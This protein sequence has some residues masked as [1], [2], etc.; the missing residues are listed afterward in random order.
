MSNF[1]I[2]QIQFAKWFD[3]LTPSVKII[4]YRFFSDIMGILLTY[5]VLITNIETF[6]QYSSIILVEFAILFRNT[7]IN[8]IAFAKIKSDAKI[9]E[10]VT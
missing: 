8:L 6:K 4:C 5:L 7:I 9:T 3:S 10:V 1:K 2:K